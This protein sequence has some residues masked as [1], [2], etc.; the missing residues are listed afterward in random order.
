MT[1][2]GHFLPLTLKDVKK[3]YLIAIYYIMKI[4]LIMPLHHSDSYSLIS[5]FTKM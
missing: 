5:K 1:T 2:G 3:L 4:L